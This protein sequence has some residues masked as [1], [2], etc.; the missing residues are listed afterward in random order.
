VGKC[1]YC[2]FNSH[3]GQPDEEAYVEALLADLAAEAGDVSNRT[4]GSIFFGGGTPSLFSPAAISRIL[5][6]V[7]EQLPLA[8]DVEITLEANPGTADAGHFAGYRAAGV[9]RLSIGVQSF[10][11]T[12]LGRLGRIHSASGA[13]EAFHL[14]RAAGF[15]NINLDLMYGLPGQ[16]PGM[17]IDDL[18]QATALDPEHLSWYQLTLEPNTAFHATPPP[19][20]PDDEILGEIAE[21]GIPLLA[22]EGYAQYEVSAYAGHDR[23]CRHNL[24]YWQFGD[25]IGIGA[26]A[27]GKLTLAGEGVVRRR[28]Q[29]HPRRYMETALAGNA[30]S[31]EQRL[32]DD[33]LLMEFMLNALRLNGGV[34]AAWIEQRTGLALAAIGQRLALARNQGLIRKEADSICPT[35]TGRQYLNDLL[36]LFS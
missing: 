17:A 27:H 28:K 34:P 25:Y 3:A 36:L 31:G 10:D 24:N 2:D 20:I 9:N 12:M 4:L 35:P 21:A 33:D 15:D 1:P 5:A 26:G 14:A 32:Q 7:R 16:T 18:Q 22:G 30:L 19:A 6:A 29:R 13:R 11:D 8:D 23:R